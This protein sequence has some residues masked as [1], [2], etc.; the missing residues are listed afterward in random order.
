MSPDVLVARSLDE[1]PPA[2]SA[3][4]IG[5]FDGVH[6][7]HRRL[8]DRTREVADERGIRAAVVTFDRNPLEV[9][10][11]DDAPPAIQSLEARVAR[12]GEAGMDLVHVLTF[13]R[14]LATQ[15]PEAFVATTLRGP[16]AAE[17]V[18]IG[19]NFRFGRGAAAGTDWLADHGREHGF[20]VEAVELADVDGRTISSTAVRRAVAAGDVAEAATLLG[21]PFAVAGTV[22]GGD[23]RGRTIGFPTANVELPEGRLR[24]AVGVYA[25]HA[26]VAGER[27]AAVTNVGRRPTFDGEGITIEVHL[28]DVDRDVYGEQLEVTFEH[29]IRDEVRFDGVDA[30][31]AQIGRDR[32]EARSLLAP[33]RDG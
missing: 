9:L 6:L 18:V 5:V 30:L 28:I 14:E 11:P 31:V 13:D 26:T 8:L 23:R 16:V 27:H 4:T 29:R 15:S 33:D 24:P 10:R 12:L 1:V 32:D 22:V 25:G 19:A 3:V 7:G 21:R 17:H 2:P 20:H